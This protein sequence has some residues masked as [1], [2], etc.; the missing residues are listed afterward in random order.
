MDFVEKSEKWKFIV[1]G[2]GYCDS[3]L[4]DGGNVIIFRCYGDCKVFVVFSKIVI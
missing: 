1:V 2:D 3:V 4:C